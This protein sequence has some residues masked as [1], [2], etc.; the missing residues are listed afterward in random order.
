MCTDAQPG[1]GACGNP[2]AFG[3]CPLDGGSTSCTQCHADEGKIAGHLEVAWLPSLTMMVGQNGFQD[4][5]DYV[6]AHPNEFTWWTEPRQDP[7]NPNSEPV[8]CLKADPGLW[9]PF[10]PNLPWGVEGE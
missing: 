9:S 1:E 6:A 4:A 2:Y 5:M 8:A 7:N 3:E 10:N